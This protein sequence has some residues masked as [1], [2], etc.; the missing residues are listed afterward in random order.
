MSMRTVYRLAIGTLAGEPEG[1]VVFESHFDKWQWLPITPSMADGGRKVFKA[2]GQL[3]YEYRG[4]LFR[5]P[6]G[7][8]LPAGRMVEGP[9]AFKGA[10]VLFDPTDGDLNAG[11]HRPFNDLLRRNRRYA[12]KVAL[13]GQGTFHFRAWI[14]GS[15]P[16]VGKTQWLGFPDLIT[17]KVAEEWH[18]YEGAFELPDLSKPPFRMEEPVS[19]AI[20]I[21]KGAR[22]FLDDFVIF[23]K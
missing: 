21:E 18:V 4:P 20:V 14:N 11:L 22:I 3:A 5:V 17:I 12:F 16:A 23:E 19:A 8:N 7:F 9:V 10:S 2:G 15:D 13:K 6:E 1:K